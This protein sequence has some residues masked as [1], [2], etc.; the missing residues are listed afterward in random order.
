M[1]IATRIHDVL[2]G[3]IKISELAKHFIDTVEFQRMHY[4]KQLSTCYLIYPNA[5]H[6]RFEHS[7]GTY[8]LCG[9]MLEQIK[10][11]VD[12]KELNEYLGTIP[13]LKKTFDD[14]YKCNTLYKSLVPYLCELI[15]IAALCHDIGHGPFCHSFDEYF[16]DHKTKSPF[17]KHEIRSGII[18]NNII[19]NS[20]YLR[21]IITDDEIEFIKNIINPKPDNVGFLYQIVS[22]YANSL[23]V[24]KCDYIVRDVYVLGMKSS[25]DCTRLLEEVKIINNNICY[26]YHS[27]NDI[28][29]LFDARNKMFRQVYCYCKVV[30]CHLMFCD[31]I[32]YINNIVNI[33]DIIINFDKKENYDHFIELTDSYILQLPKILKRYCPTIN[34]NICNGIETHQ[35]YK[36]CVTILSVSNID[37]TNWEYIND[38]NVVIYD[39][40]IGYITGNN[41]LNPL[42]NVYL[43]DKCN[44]IKLMNKNDISL[45]IP[46]IYQERIFMVFSKIKDNEFIKSIQISLNK[47]ILNKYPNNNYNIN[48]A[49]SI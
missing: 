8:H 30:G 26:N 48:N 13:E 38:D 32:K 20:E 16:H 17:M 42:D 28:F 11:N 27:S 36:W 49:G 35:I 21:N 9:K 10:L 41:K 31:Y 46:D 29:N 37:V 24:D 1:N 3:N 6:T 18:I 45:M 15:K 5:T 47:Y 12:E 2:Y 19:K 22:N 40:K 23:D 25:F 14:I 34:V 43:Y 39:S 7:I 4:I 44:N 33:E